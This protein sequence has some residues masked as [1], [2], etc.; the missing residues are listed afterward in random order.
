MAIELYPYQAECIRELWRFWKLKPRG[1]PLL[2][3]PTGSG[4]SLILSS[5]I[6]QISTKHPKYR[7]LI[8]THTKEIVEQNSQALREIMPNNLIGIYSAG[9]GQKQI[10]RITFANIQSIYKKAKSLEVGMLI[11]DEAHLTS[12]NESSMYQQLISGLQEKNPLLK[13]LGLTATPMRMDQGSLIAEGSTFTDIAYDI[14]IK[15]LIDEKY[16]TPLLSLPREAVDLSNV[17]TSGYDYNQKDLEDAFNRDALIESHCQ[18]II[19]AGAERKHWLIFCSGIDHARDVMIQFRAL[20]VDCDYITGEMC[21]W[22]RDTKLARFRNGEIRALCNVNVLTTGFNFRAVDL[23]VLLRATKSASLY[24][25]I[26]GRG[27]RTSPGKE[28]CLVLDYGG[29]IDRHGPVDLVEVKISKDKRA[30]V[31]IAPHKS[32]PLCKCVVFIKVME[33]P[34]CGFKF[35]EPTQA[36]EIAPASSPIISMPI[37]PEVYP[38]YNRLFKRHEKTGKPD[39]FKIEYHCTDGAHSKY[40]FDFLCFEHPDFAG[41]MARRKWIARGGQKPPPNTVAEALERVSELPSVVEISAVQ[42]GKYYEILS[43]KTET[44]EAAMLRAKAEQEAWEADQVI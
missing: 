10:S 5:I 15:Q 2:V 34:N 28:N 12:R 25:Q 42:K 24:V 29:N 9:L 7:F 6:S 22:E 27:A 3:A 18:D 11:I 39:S 16:L 40:L 38:V 44:L 8:A 19:K 4:K 1:A 35:P 43:T 32:C 36:L 23:V 17:K 20:G 37:T 13:I 26:V 21:A 33:C 41:S 31:G 30:T 14:S